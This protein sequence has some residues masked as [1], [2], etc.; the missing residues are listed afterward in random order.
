VPD[1]DVDAAEAFVLA[2]A[3]GSLTEVTAISEE[4][5]SLYGI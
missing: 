3:A 5:G 2:V 4:L 1:V